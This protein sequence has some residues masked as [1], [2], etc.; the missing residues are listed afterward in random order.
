MKEMTSRCQQSITDL[1]VRRYNALGI[2]LYWRPKELEL[3]FFFFFFKVG[4]HWDFFVVF[5]VLVWLWLLEK[6][7]VFGSTI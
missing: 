2:L 5:F 7:D 3:F 4:V 6:R 1:S